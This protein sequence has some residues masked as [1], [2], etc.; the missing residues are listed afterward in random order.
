MD[1]SPLFLAVF[2]GLRHGADP[3]HIAVVD[4]LTRLRPSPWNGALFA[5]GHG[6]MVLLLA[7]GLGEVLAPLE[8]AAGWLLLILGGL[9]LVKL[10]RVS[11]QFHFSLP[12]WVETGP[13]RLGTAFTPLLLGGVFGVAL[14]T[15]GQL[16]AAGTA[17]HVSPWVLG[18]IFTLMMLAI[19]GPDG[20][21]AARTQSQALTGDGRARKA[22]FLLGILV[23]IY[24]FG[25]GILDLTNQDLGGFETPLGLALVAVLLGLRYWSRRPV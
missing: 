7:I 3:E 22:S 9:T 18:G 1:L 6:L 10:G 17:S 4:G 20:Y 14:D 13:F 21:W 24:S 15:A 8:D 16:A 25:L 5:L 2:L 19:E 12:A 23:V 11:P